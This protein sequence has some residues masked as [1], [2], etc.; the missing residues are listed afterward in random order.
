[1]IRSAALALALGTSAVAASTALAHPLVD[2]GV[3]HYEQAR[4]DRALRAFRRAEAGDDLTRDDLLLLLS[5][6]ALVHHAD[7]EQEAMEADLLR[8]ATL[9]PD[10][11]LPASAPP[12]VRR[13]FERIR[14]RISEPLTLQVDIGR[15]DHGLRLAAR[16]RGDDAGLVQRV[17]LFARTGASFEA[18]ERA[19]ME[20]EVGDDEAVEYYAEAVG[21][22]GAVVVTEG[23]AESPRS[24]TPAT[25]DAAGSGGVSAGLVTETRMRRRGP[26]VEL[27]DDVEETSSSPLP[28]L[29]GGALA[30]VA[31]VV[32][33]ILLTGGSQ[34]DETVLSAPTGDF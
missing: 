29:V 18:A 19:E 23:T 32:A 16:V 8:L 6:R 26:A 21:P 33:V 11:A 20:V 28:W 17:S 25:L 24:V 4:F 27:D 15:T 7:G 10:H 9:E 3:R 30:A 22:G 14:A 2:Q 13:A 34:T 1:V 31:A 12:R 5:T